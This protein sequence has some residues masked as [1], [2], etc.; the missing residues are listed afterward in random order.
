[1]I[2]VIATI[3]LRPGRRDEFL[4]EFRRLVPLV[5]AEVGCLEYGPTV[6]ARTDI[7][8][9]PPVRDDVVVVVEKWASLAALKSHLVAAHMQEYRA[10]VKELV[11]KVELRVLESA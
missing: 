1:M 9:Q 2:H 5:R 11:A 10:R 6:D 4:A 3:E 7:A 8:A